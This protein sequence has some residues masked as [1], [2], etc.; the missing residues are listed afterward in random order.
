[1]H[2]DVM[3]RKAA[4]DILR[5]LKVQ[6]LLCRSLMARMGGQSTQSGGLCCLPSSECSRSQT[7]ISDHSS[8]LGPKS[9]MISIIVQGPGEATEPH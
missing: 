1:M 3:L 5:V 8:P 2:C 6:L 7:E 9:A 4:C